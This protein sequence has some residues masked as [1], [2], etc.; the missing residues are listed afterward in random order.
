MTL[1]LAA[2]S[3][4]SLDNSEPVRESSTRD[5][6]AFCRGPRNRLVVSLGPEDGEALSWCDDYILVVPPI[7]CLRNLFF[8]LFFDW[9]A[10]TYEDV[11]DQERNVDNIKALLGLLLRYEMVDSTSRILDFGC[12]T[13]LS[14]KATSMSYADVYGYDVSNEMRR[15]ARAAGIAVFE[16]NEFLGC[17]LQFDGVIASYTLH[18]RANMKLLTKAAEVIRPGGGIAANFHKGVGRD[19]AESAMREFG[20]ETLSQSISEA[21]HGEVVLYRKRE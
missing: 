9:I 14:M 13:G 2:L 15:R 5:R 8:N 16:N 21:G 12:G 18:C 19:W 4:K 3:H 10:E 1:K 20:M 11:I 7:E 17:N 6:L